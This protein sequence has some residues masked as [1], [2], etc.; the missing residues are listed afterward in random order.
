[1]FV[2]KEVPNNDV[3]NWTCWESTMMMCTIELYDGTSLLDIIMETN[4]K[5]SHETYRL[6]IGDIILGQYFLIPI[7]IAVMG[8]FTM[9]K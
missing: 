4:R 2:S 9:P 1:M 6:P 8:Q 3:F 7:N 5:I